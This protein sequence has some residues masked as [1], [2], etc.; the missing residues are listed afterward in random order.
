[1]SLG[2]PV[3]QEALK[4]LKRSTPFCGCSVFQR[5]ASYSPKIGHWRRLRMIARSRAV[6]RCTVY[7]LQVPFSHRR[8]G[9]SPL[10]SVPQHW[11]TS[12]TLLLRVLNASMLP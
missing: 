4:F 6:W 8:P 3:V 2:K 9:V 1:M 11:I 10:R 7:D 5:R 12:C